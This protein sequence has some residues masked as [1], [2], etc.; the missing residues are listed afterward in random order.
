MLEVNELSFAYDDE[1]PVLDHVSFKLECGMI[2]C[3]LGVNG[4]GKTTLFNCLSGFLKSNLSLE[5]E[6]LNHK[7]LYIQDEMYFYKNLTGLEF[8]ELIFSLKGKRLDMDQ[9]DQLLEK[10]RMTDYKY[11]RISTYSL[12]TK[13]KLVLIIGILLDYEYIL[14][15][16]PFA[17]IDFITAE[18][19]TDV[20]KELKRAGKTIVVSTHQLDVAQELADEVLFLNKGKIHQVTNR[21]KTPREL[22]SYLRVYI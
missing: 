8:S 17:A 2:Y 5:Q 11:E 18:V 14:M 15:D 16:E 10:L 1:K 4:A 12:G 7:L 21:F 3:L 19:I 22:K 9:F 20:L 6:F 13:Q